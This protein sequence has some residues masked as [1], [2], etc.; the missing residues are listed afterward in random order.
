MAWA[1]HRLQALHCVLLLLLLLL[2]LC[3]IALR[4][5]VTTSPFP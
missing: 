2:L 3:S 4:M 1:V 5:N